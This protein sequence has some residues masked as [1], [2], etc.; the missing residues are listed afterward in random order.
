MKRLKWKSLAKRHYLIKKQELANG[1]WR[2]GASDESY[3]AA[4]GPPDDGAA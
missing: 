1:R 4:S 3:P 2:L